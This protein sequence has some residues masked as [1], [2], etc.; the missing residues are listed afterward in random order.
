[1]QAKLK[2]RDFLAVIEALHKVFLDLPLIFDDEGFNVKNISDDKA[3]VVGLHVDK[4]DVEEYFFSGNEMRLAIPFGEF[5]DSIKKIKAPITLM[6]ENGKFIIKN[7]KISFVID[8][9]DFPD[10]SYR[11][12]TLA[13]GKHTRDTKT[14]IVMPTTDFISAVDLLSFTSSGI[15]VTVGGGKIRFAS[16]K[17]ALNATY[18]ADVEH[19]DGFTWSAA[20][21]SLYM[22]VIAKVASYT[23]KI[24][25]HLGAPSGNGVEPSIVDMDLGTNSTIF[26]I[27][28]EQVTAPPVVAHVDE[29]DGNDDD[30]EE[31][32]EVLE[33]EPDDVDEDLL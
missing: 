20:F 18:E 8:E 7:D 22:K 15:K 3:L 11:D 4:D 27:M 28:G 31:G 17:G 1:M 13:V 9:Y 33:I 14:R 23:D 24:Y 25:L 16:T 30:D 5:L 6:E 10:D 12:Y 2:N 32:Y 26:F 21:N 29:E 19:P